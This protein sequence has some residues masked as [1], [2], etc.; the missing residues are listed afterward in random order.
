MKALCAIAVFLIASP[1]DEL[2]IVAI[3]LWVMRRKATVR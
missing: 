2:L 3:A 1:L